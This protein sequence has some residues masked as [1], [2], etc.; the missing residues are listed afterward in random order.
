M[1]TWKPLAGISISLFA[2]AFIWLI[3]EDRAEQMPQPTSGTLVAQFI[4]G[5]GETVSSLK[6]SAWA[7]QSTN[8]YNCAQASAGLQPLTETNGSARAANDIALSRQALDRWGS[9]GYMDLHASQP[10]DA[11]NMAFF[12]VARINNSALHQV[13]TDSILGRVVG[14]VPSTNMLWTLNGKLQYLTT[15]GN[16]PIA[17]VP[18]AQLT[19]SPTVYGYWSN[20]SSTKFAFG[21]RIIPGTGG[22]PTAHAWTGGRI[23]VGYTA[24]SGLPGCI[25]HEW[26]F[27]KDI[28]AA[29]FTEW[30]QWLQGK[31]NGGTYTPKTSSCLLVGDSTLAGESWYPTGPTI[32]EKLAGLFPSTH[33]LSL[34][35]NGQ[36]VSTTGSNQVNKQI[37][38]GQYILNST[39]AT[40][41]SGHPFSNRVVLIMA[42]TNDINSAVSAATLKTAL[43][44][45]VTEA[46]SFGATRVGICTIMDS[47]FHDATE[48]AVRASINT[49]IKNLASGIGHDFVVNLHET[50]EG[51]DDRFNDATTNLGGV[52]LNEAGNKL[53]PSTIGR[54]SLVTIIS[55]K[56]A[57]ELG[58]SSITPNTPT[59]GTAYLTGTPYTVTWNTVGGSGNVKITLSTDGGSTY[60]I[61]LEASIADIESYSWTPTADHCGTTT[62]IKIEDAADSNVFGVTSSL[63]VATTT[64]GSG[65]GTNTDLWDNLRAIARNNGLELIE[66]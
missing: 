26:V 2:A 36:T 53:H 6:L 54:D 60:P 21:D 56:L 20:G 3:F 17:E 10:G 27:L 49:D 41:E 9:L 31:W 29:G 65:G 57:I 1:K 12:C 44:T 25:T 46:R 4:A 7:D 43:T 51:G 62:K 64:P 19:C 45:R 11:R 14:F 35:V 16:T 33:V 22:V 8:A 58:A 48:D 13:A 40:G 50:A 24:S 47:T 66:Q 59:I 18:C 52:F 23:G 28:D 38:A 61:T 39:L 5:T 55:N 63:V 34:A 37:E 32:G 15:P 42:G 30:A